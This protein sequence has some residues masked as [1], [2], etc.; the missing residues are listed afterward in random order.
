VNI[1]IPSAP[2]QFCVNYRKTIMMD[3]KQQS[4]ENDLA[5]KSSQDR[6]VQTV[7]KK[8]WNQLEWQK[9]YNPRYNSTLKAT[10]QAI[11]QQHGCVNL[12][13]L[14]QAN[15]T[16]TPLTLS[17]LGLQPTSC[18]RY[19]FWGV[20]GNP[21]C[22][23]KHDDAALTAM[24]VATVNSI[25]VEG[26]KKLHEPKA[27]QNWWAEDGSALLVLTRW[28][29]LKSTEKTKRKMVSFLN[30]KDTEQQHQQSNIKMQSFIQYHTKMQN[31]ENT[32]VPVNHCRNRATNPTTKIQKET[33]SQ[34]CTSQT[35]KHPK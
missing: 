34:S 26:A 12:G 10:K 5:H 21:A 19:K 25:M 15:G 29:Q 17:A 16:T 13:L 18:G 23:L 32:P 1:D 8:P 30:Q 9:R 2:C 31:P 20:C 14:M 4:P 7:Q 3:R 28:L 22:K 35:L 11:I 27:Q 6:M 24:Q 33:K